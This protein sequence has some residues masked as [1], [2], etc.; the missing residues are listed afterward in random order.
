MTDDVIAVTEQKSF[1]AEVGRL[2]HMM[3][4]SVYT[5]KNI[6][7]R[8]LVSNGSDACDKLRYEAI[9]NPSLMAED[10]RLSIIIRPD[11]ASGTLSIADNGIGMD[12]DELISNLGTIARSGTRAFLER[13]GEK[14][15]GAALIGQF[16]VGFYSAFMVA[17]QIEVL[18]RKAGS[19]EGNVWASNGTDGFSIRH[20]SEEENARLPRGTEIRLTLRDDSKTYL[21]P[22]V[23]ERVVKTYSDH[24]LFPVE[25]VDEL[26]GEPRQIN[27]ASALWQKARSEVTK[28][29]YS[30]VYQGLAGAYDSPRLTIHYRAEGRQSYAVL[31]FVPEQRPFDLFDPARKGRVKLYVRRVFITDDA[32]LVPTYLRFVRG[33]V[34]SEDL[35]LNISREMLQSSPTVIQMKKA[36]GARILSELEQF[37]ARDAEGYASFFDTF[38]PVLKEGL[39][40]DFER[41]DQIL[42]LARFK[43]SRHAGWRSMADYVADLRPNQTEIYYLTGDSLERLAAS[44]QLEAAHARGIEVLLMTDPIDSFWVTM[45]AEFEGKPLRSLSQGD[46]DISLVPLLDSAT[47]AAETSGKAAV[48]AVRIKEALDGAVSNVKVSNRLVSSAVCLVAPSAGPDLALDRLLS[49]QDRGFGVKPVL[50]I[51]PGHPLVAALAEAGPDI[52]S[53]EVSDIS[54]LLFDQALIL[55][56]QPPADPARF[57]ATLNRLAVRGLG[58]KPG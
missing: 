51:N 3:V 54:H 18:S 7:L 13:L 47:P 49:R 32:D 56:G 10:E 38:G 44:P 53:A 23:L 37:A 17:T 50:E 16:G 57:T 43:S 46:V 22:H 24:I 12:R 6:F 25:L 21:E 35:P 11:P 42:K 30:E 9:S 33:V 28:E 8:E 58:S 1:E 4:H 39:Y 27:A 31:L 34:D 5:E 14:G 36:L 2:L 41:R 48:L 29:Q 45:R 40:E 52:D 19:T 26:G 55:D 20:A 15:E